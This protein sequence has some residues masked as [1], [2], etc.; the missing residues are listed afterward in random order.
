[1]RI[2]VRQHFGRVRHAGKI[3]PHVDRV[4][5]KQSCNRHNDKWTRKFA[6]KGGRE[7]LATYHT[8]AGAHHLYGCHEWPCDERCPKKSCAKLGSRNRVGGNSGWIIVCR[9]SN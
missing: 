3:S 7:S 6:F 9:T 1:M 4:C 8:D 5:Q 2:V